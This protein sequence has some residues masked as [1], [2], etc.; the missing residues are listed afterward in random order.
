MSP[1]VKSIPSVTEIDPQ[2]F[3]AEH[4]L[5]AVAD[6]RIEAHGGV[7]SV[8]DAVVECPPFA[9]MVTALATG[10]GELPNR[11]EILTESIRSMATSTPEIVSPD[12]KK[13]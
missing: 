12:A 5:E 10:L 13:K 4:G 7:Y 2:V 3:I 1:E 9:K 8:R 11:E 6:L